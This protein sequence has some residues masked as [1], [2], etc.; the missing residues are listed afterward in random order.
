MKSVQTHRLSTPGG[1]NLLPGPPTTPFV[2]KRLSRTGSSLSSCSSQS[3]SNYRLS[4]APDDS[5]VLALA[6]T[7][8]SH[9]KPSIPRPPMPAS[10]P[11]RP[12]SLPAN[13]ESVSQED[14]L[15]EEI[16]SRISNLPAV[17]GS[18]NNAAEKVPGESNA[19]KA[20]P[21][22]DPPKL[23]PVSGVLHNKVNK[24]IPD[25]YY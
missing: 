4:C 12:V 1:L 23:T 19:T 7:P 2:V 17:A 9:N 18:G 13:E 25:I 16:Y 24:R 14:P 3:H 8:T 11:P 6:L 22:A 10:A 5:L 15:Y 21:P 20:A